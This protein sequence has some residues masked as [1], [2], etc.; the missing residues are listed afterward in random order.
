MREIQQ[1]AVV[2]EKTKVLVDKKWDKY[3][4]GTL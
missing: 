3:F 2:D 1:L 4:N